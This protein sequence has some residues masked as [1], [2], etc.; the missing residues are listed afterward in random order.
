MGPSLY[1]YLWN[2]F[3]IWQN[4]G[5]GDHTLL[6]AIIQHSYHQHSSTLIISPLPLIH[7]TTITRHNTLLYRK[8]NRYTKYNRMYILEISTTT[9]SIFAIRLDK[10]LIGMHNPQ[11]LKPSIIDRGRPR[12]MAFTDTVV[13]CIMYHIIFTVGIGHAI[14]HRTAGVHPVMVY[15]TVEIRSVLVYEMVEVCRFWLD[16]TIAS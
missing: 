6:M 11:D 14:V 9:S 13:Y 12:Y 10:I 15:R 16:P 3:N 5:Y 8:R 1:A 4:D 2:F 7:L